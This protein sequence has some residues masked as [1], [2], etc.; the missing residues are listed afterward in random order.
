M[1]IGVPELAR[2]LALLLKMVLAGVALG[3]SFRLRRAGGPRALT[4]AWYVLTAS[5]CLIA[6]QTLYLEGLQLGMML[7]PDRGEVLQGIRDAWYRPLYLAFGTLGA[8]VP[9]T[10]LAVLART[11]GVRRAGIALLVAALLTGAAMALA[12]APAD[13]RLFFTLTR[14]LAFLRLSAWLGVWAALLLGRLQPVDPFLMGYLA[15]LTAFALLLPLQET[16]FALFEV[17]Q[18]RVYW[19]VNQFLQALQAAGC[20]TMAGLLAR[21]IRRGEF[22]DLVAPGEERRT[23]WSVAGL[24]S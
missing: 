3:L 4:W 18:G 24:T 2:S 21:R 17:E 5:A 1:E 8:V 11:A 10:V 20:A 16:L 22:P 7:A 19:A 15:V 9:S 12:A 23:P 6:I 14:V 13:W